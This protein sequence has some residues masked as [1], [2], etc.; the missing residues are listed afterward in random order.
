MQVGKEGPQSLFGRYTSI[1]SV[2][3][4]MDINIFYNYTPFQLYDTF[5]RYFSKVSSDLYTKVST[6]PLMDVTNMEPPKDWSRNLY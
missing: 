4:Q 2:G 6:T 1:L 5:Q 3:L